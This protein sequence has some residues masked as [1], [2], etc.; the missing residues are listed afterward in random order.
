MANQSWHTLDGHDIVVDSNGRPVLTGAELNN[1]MINGNTIT[2]VAGTGTINLPQSGAIAT[3]ASSLPNYDIATYGDSITDLGTLNTSTSKKYLALGYMTWAKILTNGLFTFSLENNFGVSG[4][5]AVN[6]ATAARIGPLLACSAKIVVVLYGTN[7]VVA[8]SASYETITAAL[9]SIYQQ[10]LNAGKRVI[11]LPILPRSTTAA[12]PVLLAK[13][14]MMMRVN[15]FIQ[16]FVAA[17]SGMYFADPRKN[18]IDYTITSGAYLGDPIG[19]ASGAGAVGTG[20][21]TLTAL[22][23]TA[24]TSGCY[25]VGQIISGSGITANTRITAFGTGTGGTGTYT[26]DTSQTAASTTVTGAAN[27]YANTVDGTHPA[28]IAAFYIGKSIADVANTF[29]PALNTV[30]QSELDKI[31]TGNANSASID[32][33]SG[34]A[35]TLFTVVSGSA[36]NFAVGQ[37]LFG[38]GVTAGTKIIALGTGTGGAGTYVVDIPQLVAGGSTIL[39]SANLTGNLLSNGI[40]SGTAG[41]ITAAAGN[42][43]DSWTLQAVSGTTNVTGSKGTVALDNGA[44]YPTQIITFTDAGEGKFFQFVPTNQKLTLAV[45]DIVYMEC[46]ISVTS[47]VKM[48]NCHLHVDDGTVTSEDAYANSSSNYLATSNFSGVL[49]T[50]SFALTSVGTILCYVD[51]RVDTGGSGVVTIGKIALRKVIS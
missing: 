41:T 36:L 44:T 24:L 11:V 28:G 25:G 39:S 49:R 13:R 42:C 4:D 9:A 40:L 18:L 26:V 31:I 51:A 43:A 1:T 38:T 16:K 46:E 19:G 21:I 29:A 35:G 14:H 37:T 2:A 22:N 7:D 48:F 50:P 8:T 34:T 23:I 12:N 10:L 20:S 45:G 6:G 5:T 15:L 17:N 47:P 27:K 33:G 3:V 30:Y 32:N